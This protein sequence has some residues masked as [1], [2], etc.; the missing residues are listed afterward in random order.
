[1]TNEFPTVVLDEGVSITAFAPLI[2][3][4]SELVITFCLIVLFV[5]NLRKVARLTVSSPSFVA[6]PRSPRRARHS[7]A[8]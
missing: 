5:L 1:M 7:C 8:C 6:D 2:G 3:W 4:G